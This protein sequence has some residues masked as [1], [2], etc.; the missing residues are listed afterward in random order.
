MSSSFQKFLFLIFD[1][2]ACLIIYTLNHAYILS[3]WRNI[4]LFTERRQTRWCA[5]QS[6]KHRNISEVPW[7]S[8]Q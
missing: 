6:G 8:S 5:V 1:A 3:Q 4:Q 7:W 2:A